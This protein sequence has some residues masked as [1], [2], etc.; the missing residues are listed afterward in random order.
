MGACPSGGPVVMTLTTG[1]RFQ[2]SAIGETEDHP[3]DFASPVDALYLHVP[4]CDRKCH[5]CD[6]VIVPG[7]REAS[8]TAAYTERLLREISAFSAAQ[9]QDGLPWAAQ[10]GG[11]TPTLLSASEMR[12]LLTELGQTLDPTRASCRVEGFPANAVPRIH[13]ARGQFLSH[14]GAVPFSHMVVPLDPVLSAG[15]ALTTDMAGQAR[16]GPDL[17]FLDEP[18]YLPDDA[19]PGHAVRAIRSWWPGLDAER[20]E[21]DFVGIR[22]RVTGPGEAPGDWLVAGPA[23]HGQPRQIHLFG[24]DTPGL[25][26]CL[27]LAEHV[28]SV[29]GLSPHP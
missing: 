27:T 22:P 18:S 16:F 13:L 2:P 20:L 28:V 9:G 1:A 15:G 6:F 19:V 25:T 26:A 3:K 8:V 21:V 4:F 29:A 5:F 24:I 23:Q 7:P 12:T 14:R 11:G 17:S 10:I